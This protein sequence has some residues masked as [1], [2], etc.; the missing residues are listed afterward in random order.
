MKWNVSFGLLFVLVCVIGLVCAARPAVAATTE[1]VSVASDGTEGNGISEKPSISA[2]G[3]FVAF[4]SVV[5]NLVAGDTNGYDDIFVH[6]R[7]TEQTTRVSVASDGT[8][9]NHNSAHPAISAD[10]RFVAFDSGASNLVPDDTNGERDIF[11]HDRQTGETTRVSI[12]SDGTEGTDSSWRPSA[13][14]DGRFVAFYSYASNLV[15]GDTNGYADI[16]VHDRQTGE[17]TRVSVASG[18]DEG[19]GSSENRSISA[20]GLFVAFDSYSSNLVAGDTNGERDVFVHDRQTGQTTRVSVASDGAQGNSYSYCPSISADGLFV[21]FQSD[22]SNLVPGDTNTA[23]DIFVHDRDTGDTTR[24]SVA[25][26]GDEGNNSS[27]YPSISGDGRFMAFYSS[28]SNLVAGDTNGERDVFVHDRQT[29]Q[30]TRVSVASGGDGGNGMSGNPSVSADGA[31]VAFESMANNLVPGDT[32]AGQDIFVH[33]RGLI[34]TVT[35]SGS[36]TGTVDLSPRGGVYEEDTTVTLTA[37]PS[38]DSVFDDWD[39]DLSGSLNPETILMDGHKTVVACFIRPVLTVIS[40]PID[41]LSITGGKPGTTDYTANCDDQEV[42]SLIAPPTA[43]VNGKVGN[44][45][46]WYVDNVPQPKDQLTVQVTLD[47][48]HTALAQYDWRLPGDVTGDCIVNVLDMIFVR[49]H[50]RT[51]CPECE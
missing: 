21:A 25:A 22:A 46:R 6:E 2:D 37:H 28:A 39:G 41:A 48:N 42:V 9:G 8:Q 50:A 14:A 3:L 27:G 38:P 43:C 12:A 29:G 36:G 44:F 35:T 49:N 17:T 45:D 30:T 31:F 4:Y 19:N 23:A 24:V 51:S 20:D 16:F 11:V 7:Q 40:A 33:E 32:N 1:R 47:A 34:L 13:S 18:G 26:G 15:A 5:S 10:G